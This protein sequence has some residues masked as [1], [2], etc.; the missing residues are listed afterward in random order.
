MDHRTALAFGSR[1]LAALAIVGSAGCILPPD[2]EQV[3]FSDIWRC[4]C[5]C[6]M[7]VTEI[8]PVT[9]L[10]VDPS[11]NTPCADVGDCGSVTLFACEQG[12]CKYRCDAQDFCPAGLVCDAFRGICEAL[13]RTAP[14]T[15]RICAEA[16]DRI[17][18]CQ[19]FCGLNETLSTDDCDTVGLPSLEREDGC[20]AFLDEN[21][22]P[23]PSLNIRAALRH[24]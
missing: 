7:C 8:D 24:R 16:E 13:P 3:E 22:N 12:Q 9:G 20:E 1:S 17:D 15:F 4:S 2:V 21:Q 11:P 19:A 5:V 6:E 10:C 23:T 18:G 14:K